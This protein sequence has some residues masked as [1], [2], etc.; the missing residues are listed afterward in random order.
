MKV[1]Q[2]VVNTSL[3]FCSG[4]ILVGKELSVMSSF[5]PRVRV[6]ICK[7]VQSSFR[8]TH[9]PDGLMFWSV[10][11]VCF[12]LLQIRGCSFARR[13][14]IKPVGGIEREG[15]VGT[16]LVDAAMVFGGLV[17]FTPG[18]SVC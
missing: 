11:S 4:G 5:F 16:A 6:V 9:V 1:K 14:Q 13:V 15:E 8:P 10:S 3:S 12:Q 18:G 17:Y 7:P 2:F